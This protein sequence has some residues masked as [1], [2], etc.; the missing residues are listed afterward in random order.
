M[1]ANVKIIISLALV[2]VGLIGTLVCVIPSASGE[3]KIVNKYINAIN[4]CN[5]KAIKDCLPLDEVSSALGQFSSELGIDLD[6]DEV[7]DIFGYDE[8]NEK[9]SKLDYLR[10][11]GLDVSSLVPSDAKEVNKIS[12]I[13]CT[14]ADSSED[15]IM[16]P[17]TRVDALVKV[18]YKSADDET[19]S[20]TDSQRFT[21]VKTSKGY[22]ISGV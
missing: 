7:K 8:S 13:S 6:E 4:S 14:N 16:S 15:S 17:T 22:K 10:A 11:S 20:V 2:V 21:V 19:V 5:D 1:K 3:Y 9:T 12:L 18:V